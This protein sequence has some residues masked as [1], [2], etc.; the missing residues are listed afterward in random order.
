MSDFIGFEK[1][2]PESVPAD[3]MQQLTTFPKCRLLTISEPEEQIDPNMKSA[4]SCAITGPD[5]FMSVVENS[6]ESDKI[7]MYNAFA[8]K[9]NILLKMLNNLNNACLG[10]VGKNLPGVVSSDPVGWE[11]T[12]EFV[13][14]PLK[15]K[16]FTSVTY[17]PTSKVANAL[18]TLMLSLP[19]EI[20]DTE[21]TSLCPGVNMDNLKL[22]ASLNK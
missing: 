18:A 7:A 5:A 17:N 11:F 2:Y 6:S 15:H 9:T 13:P 12:D 3:I 1:V 21:M 22:F 19:D 8:M 16:C 4:L 10:M 14:A 20:N